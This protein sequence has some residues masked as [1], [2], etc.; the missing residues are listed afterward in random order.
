MNKAQ[1]QIFY[2]ATYPRLW[3]YVYRLVV[4]PD[5][6]Q[7]L[8]QESYMRFLRSSPRRS[9]DEANRSYLFAIATNLVKD[10][11]RRGKVLGQWMEGADTDAVDNSAELL[12]LRLDM[13][14]AMER[15]S[16]MQR[17]LLWLT[18][19]EGYSHSEVAAM[20]QI[21]PASVR[22]LLM[23]ARRRLAAVCQEMGIEKESRS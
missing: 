16:L 18:Y 19:V 2:R 8:V 9:S 22:V 4:D 23:R 1:F 17:S 10:S 21:Q 14:S 6:S 7:D 20:Q 5:L 13:A 12:P 3:S 15:L 11:W